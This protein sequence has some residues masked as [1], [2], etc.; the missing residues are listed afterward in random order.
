[1]N[2]EDI[3]KSNYGNLNYNLIKFVLD[4]SKYGFKLDKL[5]RRD[6]EFLCSVVISEY[7]HLKTKNDIMQSLDK[8]KK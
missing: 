6:L 7:R 1:M 4:S 8:I 5:S 2:N 3:V